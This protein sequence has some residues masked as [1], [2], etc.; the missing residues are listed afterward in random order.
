MLKLQN[1]CVRWR[2]MASAPLLQPAPPAHPFRP[3]VGSRW[4]PGHAAGQSVVKSRLTLVQAT[5]GSS[6]ADQAARIETTKRIRSL[7]RS[8]RVRDAISE[9]ASLARLGVQPDA[10]AATSL[11][12]ACVENGRADLAENV[13]NELFA[14]DAL[15]P[16]EIAFSVLIRGMGRSKPPRWDSIMALLDTMEGRWGLQPSAP[17]FNAL[18][19]ICVRTE[20]DARAD[21][22]LDRMWT[23]GV[24][25]DAM[26]LETVRQNK[27]L[28][29]R[30]KRLG[31]E[32]GRV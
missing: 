27:K 19:D 32:V 5:Q 14:D 31:A 17:V 26:T 8:G 24:A 6:S 3:H 21:T 11:L 10:M 29:S 12:H 4:T 22:L 13:F 18:L 15:V 9:L 20:D 25:P 2:A 28:R 1:A 30:V 7:G 16:D 23:G